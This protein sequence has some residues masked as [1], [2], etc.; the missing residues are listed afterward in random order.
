MTIPW[1]WP[2]LLSVM[3]FRPWPAERPQGPMLGL[4]CVAAL[5]PQASAAGMSQERVS[6]S[7]DHWGGCW[8]ILQETMD[9]PLNKDMTLREYRNFSLKPL[10]V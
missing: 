8:E 10:S 1:Y 7:R 9:V 3:R 6:L 2:E 5:W 4:G